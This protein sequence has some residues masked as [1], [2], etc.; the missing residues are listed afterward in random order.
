MCYN[1]KTS[2]CVWA[3]VFF[4]IA[5]ALIALTIAF[6]FIVNNLA[7]KS[8]QLTSD[9]QDTWANIP[10]THDL[11]VNRDYYLYDCTNSDEMYFAGAKP[12]CTEIGPI[13]F[14]ENSTYVDAQYGKLEI[15]G[16]NGKSKVNLKYSSL[17]SSQDSVILN[18]QLNLLSYPETF[19]LDKNIS[20]VNQALFGLWY[21][22][23]NQASFSLATSGLF[24][25]WQGFAN[26]A[27]TAIVALTAQI[28]NIND[29]ATFNA[30]LA[31]TSLTDEQKVALW[32]DPIY[33]VSIQAP[34]ALKSGKL[35]YSIC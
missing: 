33:G 32:N 7:T 4:V 8:V 35:H 9:N 16:E 10:G 17:I 21:G 20:I 27:V 26:D 2:L 28:S 25:V 13:S 1:S 19:D 15:P 29:Q 23:G 30:S 12:E 34:N 18:Y 5:A 24:N 11:R 3:I 14:Y 22:A 31:S 6:P